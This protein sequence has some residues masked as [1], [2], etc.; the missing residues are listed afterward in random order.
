[1]RFRRQFARLRHRVA[2]CHLDGEVWLQ[3]RQCRQQVIEN[4]LRRQAKFPAPR[5]DLQPALPVTTVMLRPRLPLNRM[6]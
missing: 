6:R 1:M 5:A 3:A 4:L 2:V